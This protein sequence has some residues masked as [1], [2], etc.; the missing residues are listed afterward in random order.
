MQS[1]RLAFAALAV[2]CLAAAAAGGYLA[3]RSVEPTQAT[4]NPAVAIAP[5]AQASPATTAAATSQAAPRDVPAASA[6]A[7]VPSAGPSSS[8][9][10]TAPRPGGSSSRSGQTE[11]RATTRDGKRDDVRATRP[12]AGAQSSSESAQEA[13]SAPDVVTSTPSTEERAA[14]NRG[15]ETRSAE[16]APETLTTEVRSTSTEPSP[17]EVVQSGFE[18]LMVAA[19]SVIGLRLERA[20]SSERAKVEDE[21]DARVVRDVRVGGEVAIPAGSRAI[22][23]VTLVERGGRL[24]D[25]A[26]LAIRFHTLVLNDGTRLPITTEAIFRYGDS[27]GDS[28]AKKIGTGAVAGAILGA[29]IGGGKGAALGAAAGA[30]GGTAM[31]MAGNPSAAEFG[32]GTEV[33]AR[34]LA[35]VTVTL[36]R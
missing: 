30:G 1:N 17:G 22:G 36:E 5:Q 26:R 18:E 4:G 31:V 13:T 24:K 14:D 33:T 23:S 25:R 6:P 27:P 3:N 12:T 10:S 29:I 19:D 16:K 7:S 34:I 35:P 9:S 15:L 8:V 2:A 21:V 11:R 28:S 32:A 20:V